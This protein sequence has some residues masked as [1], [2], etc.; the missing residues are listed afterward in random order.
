[1]KKSD[2]VDRTIRPN[3][4]E[5]MVGDVTKIGTYPSYAAASGTSETVGDAGV[6]KTIG[7]PVDGVD[8]ASA[9]DYNP[10]QAHS[11]EGD[12]NQPAPPASQF[13]P[14][15]ANPQQQAPQD[16]T[17]D[18]GSVNDGPYGE[19]VNFPATADMSTTGGPA[20]STTT[21]SQITGSKANFPPAADTTS[22]G[23]SMKDVKSFTPQGGDW[24]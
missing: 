8:G 18:E 16:Q 5:R 3:Q 6:P 24:K 12:V 15:A 17:R 1:M 19:R 4:E 9:T 20:K 22:A 2:V 13:D 21:L 10:S 7:S 11:P 23:S 14:R